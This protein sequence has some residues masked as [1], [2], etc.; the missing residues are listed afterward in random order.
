MRLILSLTALIA[1]T[2]CATPRAQ[3]EAD[4]AAPYRAALREQARNATD[5]GRGFT[6]ETK[7]ERVRRRTTCRIAGGGFYPCYE[8]DLQPVTRR[9]PIDTAALQQRQ[10]ELARAIPILRKTAGTDTA[11]CRALY[12]EEAG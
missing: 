5:L 10:S 8:T 3:C 11:Q 12:P 1:L 9:V 6:F 4:A 7:F 2:A